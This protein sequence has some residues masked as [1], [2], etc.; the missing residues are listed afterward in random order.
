MVTSAS[1][2]AECPGHNGQEPDQGSAPGAQAPHLRRRL[3]NWIQDQAQER[4]H[5]ACVPVKAPATLQGLIVSDDPQP[6]EMSW[7]M[8]SL[9][10][11][12]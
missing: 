7:E 6:T 8:D 3:T 4:S 2:D 1:I 12:L 9:F 11:S 5:M 10:G